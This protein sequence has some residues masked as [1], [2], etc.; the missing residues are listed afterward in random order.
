MSFHLGRSI[1]S[2]IPNIYYFRQS[3]TEDDSGRK[4]EPELITGFE[5]TA[6][7]WA[8]YFGF[9]A[10]TV[11]VTQTELQ[12]VT[13][14]DPRIVVTFAVKGCRPLRIPDDLDR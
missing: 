14:R 3:V 4:S 10:P 8:E 7:G 5:A 12:T 11:T 2:L 1:K 13:A 9:Y 6:L